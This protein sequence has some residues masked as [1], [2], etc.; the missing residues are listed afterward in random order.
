MIK[1]CPVVQDDV[2]LAEDIFGKDVAIIKGKAQEP[3]RNQ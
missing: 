1:H 3:S 2:I